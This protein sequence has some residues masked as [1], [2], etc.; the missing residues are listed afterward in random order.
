MKRI[1]INCR[2][3][4]SE[5]EAFCKV[6]AVINSGKISNFG[7]QYCYA[8]TFKS[9]V[10]VICRMTRKGNF[11]FDVIKMEAETNSRDS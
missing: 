8:T 7:K 3:G 9:G 5:E 6:G 2:D 10:A 1:I 11:A 4:I